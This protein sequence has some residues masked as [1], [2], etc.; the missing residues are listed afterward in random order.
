[1]SSED[2]ISSL[3][4]GAAVAGAVRAGGR[5]WR[6]CAEA[7]RAG[8]SACRSAHARASAQRARWGEAKILGD[9]QKF[10]IS[11]K[12]KTVRHCRAADELR[13]GAAAY[14]GIVCVAPVVSSKNHFE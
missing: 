12:G 5:G 14:L 13:G 8:V 3:L 2:H 11:G 6:T 4:R 1:M 9:P 10:Q 7:E